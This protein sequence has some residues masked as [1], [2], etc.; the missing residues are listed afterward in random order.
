MKK[1]IDEIINTGDL[2]ELH[3]LEKA[4]K[5]KDKLGYGKK[6]LIAM[7][8]KKPFVKTKLMKIG[9]EYN[10]NRRLK[11]EDVEKI[12]KKLN[13]KNIVGSYRRGKKIMQDVDIISLNYDETIK[14]IPKNAVW[15][16]R[17]KKKISFLM[18][19]KK[20][21]VHIDV[22]FPKK[23]YYGS[24]MLYFTGSK[25]FNLKMRKKAKMLGWKLNEYGLFMKNKVI[26]NEKEIIDKLKFDKKYYD[27][28]NRDL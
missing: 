15:I 7:A 4:V 2:K 12:A 24:T 20:R 14:N 17:G 16:T 28:K 23:K 27:P 9:E 21:Y 19:Y 3:D 11:R 6:A 10:I 5:R 22:V 8:L 25:M 18:K 1:K 26:T 13:A